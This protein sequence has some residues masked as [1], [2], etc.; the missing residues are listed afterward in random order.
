MTGAPLSSKFGT[1]TCYTWCMKV[2]MHLKKFSFAVGL[3]FLNLA[4]VSYSAK[5]FID[6]TIP[7]TSQ[8]V[9]IRPLLETE[10]S[11]GVL[12]H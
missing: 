8:A 4:I 6:P 1:L 11:T 9:D 12:Q 10:L 3:K 2:S 5:T 7:T